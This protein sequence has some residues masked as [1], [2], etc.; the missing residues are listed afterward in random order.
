MQR[1]RPAPASESQHAQRE[2]SGALQRALRPLQGMGPGYLVGVGSNLDPERNVPVIVRTLLLEF[3]RLG[4]SPVIRTRPV[5][6]L[7]H[8]DFLN[9]VVFVETDLPVDR[10]KAFFNE[11]EERLGRDRSDRARHTKDRPADL[12]ILMH[13]R[14]DRALDATQYPTESYLRPPFLALCEAMGLVGNTSETG[15]LQTVALALNGTEF[16]RHAQLLCVDDSDTIRDCADLPEP[17]LG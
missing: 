15:A 14:G 5:G 4:V 13:W 12:D 16:G 7:S 17:A 3:G 10:L 2:G 9:A 8:H 6:I 11:V 1:A